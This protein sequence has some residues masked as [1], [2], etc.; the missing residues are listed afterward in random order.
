MLGKI[1]K[2]VIDARPVSGSTNGNFDNL[3]FC[4]DNTRLTSNKGPISSASHESGALVVERAGCL[5]QGKTCA[6]R[7]VNWFFAKRLGGL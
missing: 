5:C 1:T 4:D 7:F 3:V 2:C 6:A